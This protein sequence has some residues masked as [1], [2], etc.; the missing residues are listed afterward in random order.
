MN[1]LAILL[2]TLALTACGSG[3]GTILGGGAPPDETIVVSAPSLTVP[4]NFSLRPPRTGDDAREDVLRRT[5]SVA[6]VAD[7]VEDAWLL[8][9]ANK[10]AN[11]RADENIREALTPPPE[12]VVEEGAAPTNEDSEWWEIWKTTPQISSEKGTVEERVGQ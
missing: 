6:P 7:G 1:K 2:C 10:A 11:T 5:P 3:A 12:P 8:Q 9:N 4:P